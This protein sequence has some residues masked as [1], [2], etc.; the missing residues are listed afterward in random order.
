MDEF[1][2]LTLADEREIGWYNSGLN[3]GGEDDESKEKFKDTQVDWA[4]EQ[5]SNILFPIL[6]VE[7]P[8]EH[9]AATIMFS[10]IDIKRKAAIEIQ[11]RK[12]SLQLE[13][14]FSFEGE[15]DVVLCALLIVFFML[16]VLVVIE[17]WSP[18]R[19]VWVN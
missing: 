15:Y 6:R 16:F 17:C 18:M 1:K 12:L 3:K 19:L 2:K 14:K 5:Q 11:L 9:K 10:K 8:I 13:D 7:D 4:F